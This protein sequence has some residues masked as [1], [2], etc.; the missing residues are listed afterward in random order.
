MDWWYGDFLYGDPKLGEEPYKK[1]C[2]L[3]EELEYD[4]YVGEN[5][6]AEEYGIDHWKHDPDVADLLH[7]AQ[8]AKC[9]ER[10]EPFT[11]ADPAVLA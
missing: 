2:L 5:Y 8:R 10:R 3:R 6:K 11:N 9:C 4:T 1:Q 7:K